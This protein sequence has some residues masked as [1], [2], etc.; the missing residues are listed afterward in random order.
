MMSFVLENTGTI[1]LTLIGMELFSWL[2]HKYLFHGP[3]W[4]IHQTHHNRTVHTSLEW[5]DVFSAGF[6]LLA[7]G[8]IYSGCFTPSTLHLAMGLGITIYGMVYFVVHDGLIHQRYPF[9]NKTSNAYLKQ[10]QRAHQRHHVSP[11]KNPS[12]EFGLFFMIGRRYW[13]EVFVDAPHAAE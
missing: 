6:G 1:V 3:L 7:I 13:R 2:I 10:V 8:L 5:N 9:W 4:F 12:E 11:Y